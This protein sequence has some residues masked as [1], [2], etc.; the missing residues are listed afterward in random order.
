[1]RSVTF[2]L[3]MLLSWNGCSAHGSAGVSSLPSLSANAGT[4]SSGA[5]PIKHIVIIVQEGRT[6]E[7]LFA[8][9]PHTLSTL[10]GQDQHLLPVRLHEMT[11]S[12]DRAVCELYGCMGLAQAEFMNGFELNRF[13]A[14]G[15]PKV[16][17]TGPSVGLYPYAYMNH[18]EIE[19]YRLMASQYVLAEKMYPSETGG[20]FTAHQD[21]ISG[22]TF[23]SPT[24]FIGDVPSQEPW[25]CDAPSGT[26][27]PLISG[28]PVLAGK[29]SPC[30]TQYPTM[31]DTMDAAGVSWKYYVAPIDGRDPS[32][33]LWNAFDAISKVRYGP[34]WKRNIVSPPSRVLDDAKNGTLPAVSWVI[35]ELAWSDHPASTSDMG[36]SWVASVVNA[37]GNGP[38]WKSTAIIVVWSEWGGFYEWQ[39]PPHPGDVSSSGVGFRV[40]C[41]II[42]P[43]AKKGYISKTLYQFGSILQLVERT[44]SLPPLSSAGYGYQFTDVGLGTFSMTDP[45]DF[46]QQ[47]RRF[48]TIPAKYP[49]STFKGR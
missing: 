34:D 1:M 16:P 13:S 29:T 44:F 43:Y 9:W 8:G 48:V 22:S 27:V 40:P 24:K 26:T 6:F 45:F 11:Y 10:V 17:R 7:N 14:L 31:A 3:V 19:P 42:S 20:D 2:V 47:P 37:I 38:D 28:G 25:G 33:K 18:A 36:P 39:D 46:A 32:G 5:S 30:I 49:A 21:L 15:S 41:L 4:H 35:P 12:Q 23:V